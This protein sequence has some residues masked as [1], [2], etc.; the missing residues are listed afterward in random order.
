MPIRPVRLTPTVPPALVEGLTALEA[1][2]QITAEFPAEVLAD[3]ERSAADPS[4]P[5]TDLTDLELVTIDPPGSRDLDQALFVERTGTG[6][7]VHY[8]IADVAAFVRPG[9]PVDR[10]AHRRGQT[11]Y[12]PHR[13]IALHP[14]VLSEGAASLLADQVAPAVVWQLD[15]DAAGALTATGCRRALVRSREQLD[16]AEAQR[17]LDEGT[18]SDSL[19]G[20]REVGLLREQQERDRGGISLP[21]PEQEVHVDDD[22]G[23]RLAYRS[24]LPVEGWNAQISLLTGAAAAQLMLRGRVG[25]L[26]TLPPADEHS[27]RRLRQTARAL[28]IEWPEALA[29]PEFVRSL[30][31]DHGP[32]AA[33]LRA[34]TTLFRGAG[35][36][37]FD[38]GLPPVVE[39]AAIAG[40]YAHTT[41]PLRRLVDRYVLETCLA[42][43]G[44]REVPAWVREALE[45]LPQEMTDSGRRASAYERR[46]VDMAEALVLAPRV[47]QD[48]EGVV[49]DLDERG[50]GDRPPRGRLVI[51]DPAVEASV[52][53]S[54]LELGAEVVARLETAD[55]AQGRVSFVVG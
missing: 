46:V 45:A 33:M 17:R 13:R 42:L 16:Y 7:R 36:A 11:L 19:T 32:H 22:G 30:D 28:R 5:G 8:A 24:P 15:V 20:L 23:W 29:Y 26:R 27:L 52:T 38:G 40:S 31:P 37:A 39:H 25:V 10:E 54:P 34:C 44:D 2:L 41:A 53:G 43:C 55:P 1:E 49:V 9:S 18:A 12:A 51:R 3:A 35:Y 48:F 47:G 21:I 6:F 4:L 50:D 14:P